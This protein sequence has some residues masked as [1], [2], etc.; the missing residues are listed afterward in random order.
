VQSSWITEGFA[1]G[2]VKCLI[3]GDMLM[4]FNRV[5][6][7]AVILFFGLSAFYL[8]LSPSSIAGQGYT[9]EEINSG[10]RML[11]V[12][13]AW[14]KGRPI[15]PM[16]WSR[17]GPI[18]VLFDLPFIKLGKIFVSP[19]FVLSFQPVLLTAA[20]LTVLYV[21]LRKLCSPG[22]SLLLTL[23]GAFGTMLWP[24]AYISLETKQSLFLLLAGYLALGAEDRRSWSRLL[25][26]AVTC[27]LAVSL[28]ANGIVL[29]PVLA[30]LLYVQFRGDW[31]SRRMQVLVAVCLIGFIWVVGALGR[32]YYW[33]P[34]GGGFSV[35]RSW[36]VDSP[37]YIF[38]N[39]VGIF[40]S[41]TKGL[42]VYAPVLLVA[43]YAIP[44]AFRTHRQTVVFAL[45][46]TCCTLG[47]LCSLRT[48]ADEVWGSRYMHVT[49]CPLLLCIGAARPGFNRRRDIPLFA[50]ATLGLLISF[51]GAFYYY[52]VQDF[53]AA[54][55]A[56]NTT[57]WLTGDT[58]WNHIDFNARLFRVWLKGGTVPALWT[59]RHYWVWRPPPGA[60]EWKSMDL[61]DFCQP[62][63]FM[64]RF[65]H[66]PKNGVVLKIFRMYVT[67]LLL[68]LV[69]LAW[70]V[71]RTLMEDR[72]P[73]VGEF[74]AVAGD[75]GNP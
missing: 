46:V 4:G 11:A 71:V 37:F 57:E 17:H 55:A 10:L 62:Q 67:S 44:R 20:L 29:F 61:R 47:L 40:G 6:R 50:L 26:L 58:V 64:V 63:S 23:T 25:L 18:P 2:S 69:F 15:P 72:S 49:I 39:L 43:V 53:A 12:V 56:Q 48:F 16:V 9:G 24:Y 22:M 31:R 14:V 32:A 60:Q 8:S 35:L 3:H 59:P 65:W 7:T 70:A 45:L 74:V 66:V 28:K 68:G 41:P 73:P 42:F 27:G 13:N 34:R 36:F 75:A 38:S 30:Y 1:A 51:L 54:R 21:W 33:G 52:G 5:H 19:D